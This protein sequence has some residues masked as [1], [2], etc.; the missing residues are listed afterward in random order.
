VRLQQTVIEQCRRLDRYTSELLDVGRIQAG[1]NPAPLQAVDMVEIANQAIQ[2]TKLAYPDAVILR[3]FAAGL[4]LI[5]GNAAILEQA[6]F[7]LVHNAARYGGADAVTIAVSSCRGR[8]RLTITDQGPGVAPQEQ[9]RI[10]DRFY[11]I[12]SRS[13]DGGSGLGLFIA[14]GFIKAC[15][16]SIRVISPVQNGRGTSMV[17]EFAK[18]HSAPWSESLSQ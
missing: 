16:G 3:D 9:A 12:G 7:N 1:L 10:F 18:L 13:S 4:H 8:T 14:K 6:L 15:G 5:S 2:Q 17:V 11:R